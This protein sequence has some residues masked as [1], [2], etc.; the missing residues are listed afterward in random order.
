MWG[1]RA[2]TRATLPIG[3]K[4]LRAYL[5]DMVI[6]GG[7]VPCLYT[8][9]ERPSGEAVALK[10]QDPDVAVSRE[11]PKREKPIDQPLALDARLGSRRGTPIDAG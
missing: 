9:H 8:A 1:G 6:A 4:A 5:D 11:V 3:L 2:S 7:W 10:T